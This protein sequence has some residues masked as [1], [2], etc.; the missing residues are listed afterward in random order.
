[1]L[2]YSFLRSS[3]ATISSVLRRDGVVRVCLD[4]SAQAAIGRRSDLGLG[5]AAPA[6]HQPVVP[7]AIRVHRHRSKLSTW[8]MILPSS[9]SK[10]AST[11]L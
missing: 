9:N 10:R 3:L 7:R 4:E 11:L 6:G 5:E 1:M 2:R 8:R